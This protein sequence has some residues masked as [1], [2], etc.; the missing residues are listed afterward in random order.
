[1]NI[2]TTKIEG[3]EHSSPMG[4][5]HRALTLNKL[6]RHVEDRRENAYRLSMTT[7]EVVLLLLLRDALDVVGGLLLVLVLVLQWCRKE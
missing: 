3:K 1:M 4:G 7:L 5:H 2:A 6:G